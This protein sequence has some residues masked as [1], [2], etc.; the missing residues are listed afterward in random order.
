MKK[1]N[2]KWRLVQAGPGVFERSLAELSRAA[3]RHVRLAPSEQWTRAAVAMAVPAVSSFIPV[4]SFL[5]MRSRSD[6]FLS[7][8]PVCGRVDSKSTD[9]E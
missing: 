1:N 3:I 5:H 4:E 2:V 8:R 7:L 9:Y 6:C